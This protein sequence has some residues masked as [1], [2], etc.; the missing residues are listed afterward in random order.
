MTFYTL[1]SI[2]HIFTWNCHLSAY[3][4]YGHEITQH[5]FYLWTAI[6]AFLF[7]FCVDQSKSS[8]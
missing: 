1:D 7:L 2:D 3:L 6:N 5:L 8:T 4:N